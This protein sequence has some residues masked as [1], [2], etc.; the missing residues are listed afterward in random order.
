MRP[1]SQADAAAIIAQ[2][3]QDPTLLPGF[4]WSLPDLAMCT[5]GE[6]VCFHR[7]LALADDWVRDVWIVAPVSR[8]LSSSRRFCAHLFAT[9]ARQLRWRVA[10]P[11]DPRREAVWARYG[12]RPISLANG[13]LTVV[14]DDPSLPSA[15]AEPWPRT[16]RLGAGTSFGT[17]RYS[18]FARIAA[19][20]E[21]PQNH[22][23]LGYARGPTVDE[24]VATFMPDDPRYHAHSPRN[25]YT[26]RRGGAAVG[27]V[28][29]HPRNYDGDTVREID[30]VLE[31]GALPLRTWAELLATIA[32]LSFRRGATRML[33]NV[34]EDFEN[35]ANIFGAEKV[36]SWTT[37]TTPRRSHYTATAAQFYA[38]VAARSYA[39]TR[40]R[41]G[42][43]QT[44]V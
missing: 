30:M 10:L 38:S 24:L 40:G 27:V 4:A 19:L 37:D 8:W 33:V 15:A 39:L 35:M 11:I 32:D 21:V 22:Q 42:R 13:V 29:E 12:A 2:L 1:A 43:G 5:D 44:T 17:A 9:G 26:V 14:L 16:V 25:V 3:R 7:G 36:T 6:A 31:D 28:I 23:A 34:R 41:R 20:L 18:E